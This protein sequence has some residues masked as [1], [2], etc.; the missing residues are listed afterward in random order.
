MDRRQN[1]GTARVNGNVHFVSD[2]NARELHQGAVEDDPLGV[3]DLGDGLCHDVILCLT[4]RQ[5][6]ISRECNPNQE[7]RK[8][9]MECTGRATPFAKAMARQAYKVK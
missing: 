1:N 5:L 2:F 7:A 8:A 9:G 4:E 6:S 3:S